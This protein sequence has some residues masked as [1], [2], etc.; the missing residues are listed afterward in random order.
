MPKVALALLA[1]LAGCSDNTSQTALDGTGDLV[2][3]DSS[4]DSSQPTDSILGDAPPASGI[5]QGV[6]KLAS[7]GQPVQDENICIFQGGK[8]TAQCAKTDAAGAFDLSVPM[9]VEI[10][11]LFDKPG[12]NRFALPLVVDKTPIDVGTW[13]TF[14]EAEASPIFTKV[15]VSYP[16]QGEGAFTINATAGAKIALVP[17][18]G[19]GPYYWDSNLQPDL[20]LTEMS[21][22]GVGVVVGLAPGVYDVLVSHPTLK[23]VVLFGW[24]A[25]TTTLRGPVIDGYDTAM[26]T[27]CS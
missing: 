6:V 3:L 19:K 24:T 26:M 14:T 15:G 17:S 5:V 11:L 1:V 18:A 21:S 4:Q 12:F 8:K 7:N 10:A 23:C 2:L 20:S 9:N 25:P 13:R 27:Q 22:S 16:L